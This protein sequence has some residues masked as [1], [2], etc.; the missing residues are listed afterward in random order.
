M[1]TFALC[2]ETPS[3]LFLSLFRH[4]GLIQRQISYRHETQ[5]T[6]VRIIHIDTVRT[7]F[8]KRVRA[9]PTVDQHPARNRLS[10]RGKSH[11]PVVSRTPH[12]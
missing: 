2:S 7:T 4:R 1:L 8:H 3:S 12:V 6:A 5:L 10:Q 11:I 9:L